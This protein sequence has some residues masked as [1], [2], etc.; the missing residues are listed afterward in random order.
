M[1]TK[2]LDKIFD[3]GEVD[4]TN[5]LDLSKAFRPGHEQKR[6]NVDFPQWMITELDKESS[7]LGVPRQSLIKVWLAE[8]LEKR[9]TRKKT[10]IQPAGRANG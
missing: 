7:R 10:R 2:D 4:I 1:K 3:D 9:K 5:Y 6:V 8:R